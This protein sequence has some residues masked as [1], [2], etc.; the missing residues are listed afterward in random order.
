MAAVESAKP[1]TPV[2][3]PIADTLQGVQGCDRLVSIVQQLAAAGLRVG[4][5][6]ESVSLEVWR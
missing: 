6:V 3:T 2:L 5:T 4:M 1:S